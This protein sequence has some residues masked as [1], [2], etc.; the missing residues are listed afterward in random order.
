MLYPFKKALIQ[1]KSV[2]DGK[3][4]QTNMVLILVAWSAFSTALSPLIFR[5]GWGVF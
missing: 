1:Q 2:A 5:E 3:T 4:M